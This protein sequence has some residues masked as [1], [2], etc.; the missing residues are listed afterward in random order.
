MSLVPVEADATTNFDSKFSHLRG[1]LKQ[2]NQSSSENIIR[3]MMEFKD[4]IQQLDQLEESGSLG[5]NEKVERED[6]KNRLHKFL[7]QS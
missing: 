7:V 2:W 1:K 4:R 3:R 6:L 5:K